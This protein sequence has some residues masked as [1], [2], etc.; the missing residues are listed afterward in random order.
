M[1]NE[2]SFIDTNILLYA[3]AYHKED[4]LAWINGVYHNIYIHIDVLNEVINLAAQDQISRC[5]NDYHWMIFN[6]GELTKDDYELYLF[7]RNQVAEDMQ[8]LALRRRRLGMPIKHTANVGE[9]SILAAC[10]LINGTIICSND[11]DV[12]DVIDQEQYQIIDISTQQEVLIK[13]EDIADFCVR[14]NTNKIATR[15]A[16]R[17]FYGVIIGEQKNRDALLRTLDLRMASVSE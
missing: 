8:Q 2:I 10:R 13:Q 15:K 14:V 12:R 5:I 11:S 3:T 16:V 4:I 17:K 7:L 9:I 6:P 1:T